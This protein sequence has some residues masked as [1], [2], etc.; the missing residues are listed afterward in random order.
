MTDLRL[1]LIGCG[2]V[3]E[4]LHLPVAASV[5]GVAVRALVDRDL[6][7]ARAL[8]ESFRV[9]ETFDHAAELIG[10]VDAVIV[11][12]PHHL[13]VEIALE[14]LRN[15]IH[16]LVEKPM[17]LDTAGCDALIAAALASGATLAVGLVRR[18]YTPARF[19][20]EILQDGVIGAV[21]GFDVREGAIFNWQVATDATFRKD[22]GGG[23]LFDIGTH[24]LDLLLWWLG[25]PNDVQYADDAMGGV[26]ADCEIRLTLGGAAG[27]VEL[28]RTRVLRNTMRIVGERGALE[29]GPGFDPE[30]RLSLG[31]QSRRLIGRVE[32]PGRPRLARLEDVFVSQLEDFTRAV[33]DGITPFIPGREGRRSVALIEACRKV[34]QP[35]E[36]PWLAPPP[37]QVPARAPA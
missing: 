14:M 3:T 24:V 9:P 19:V 5:P 33:R 1:A 8:A 13:H 4:R 31:R 30:V 11:A 23:V 35:L 32:V 16:V 25:E 15:G 28:S 29:I 36:F 26:E 20:R 21:T 18:F 17:A 12:V 6:P 7:R 22:M 27:I 2:K 34:R 10:R 37:V